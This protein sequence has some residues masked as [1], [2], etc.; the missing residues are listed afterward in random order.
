MAGRGLIGLDKLPGRRDEDRRAARV[1][2]VASTGRRAERTNDRGSRGRGLPNGRRLVP[3]G[4]L[5]KTGP[6]PLE[7]A[8]KDRLNR[9][10]ALRLGVDP[11]ANA[12]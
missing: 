7:L 1:A 8:D 6:T 2:V 3:A 4:L 11:P 12:P 9:A 10:V 5:E